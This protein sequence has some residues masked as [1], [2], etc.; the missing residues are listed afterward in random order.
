MLASHAQRHLF[1]AHD[2]VFIHGTSDDLP[3]R[4][5][6]DFSAGREGEH[7]VTGTNCAD[8]GFHSVRTQDRRVR[9]KAAF[10]VHHHTVGQVGS[11]GRDE[12]IERGPASPYA[13]DGFDFN[14]FEMV[15]RSQVK[16]ISGPEIR[17][18]AKSSRRGLK[19]MFRR[20]PQ[21][22]AADANLDI[23]SRLDPAGGLHRGRLELTVRHRPDRFTGFR[24]FD[25]N[26]S[27]RRVNQRALFQATAAA[28]APGRAGQQ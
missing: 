1:R 8:G 12:Q 19:R 26:L 17:R 27:R 13:G 22:L 16:W 25:G 11:A 5:V 4:R 6:D 28:A 2:K 20:D 23:I 18:H 3:H 24:L 7:F 9:Q 10:V 21:C 14:P 15:L